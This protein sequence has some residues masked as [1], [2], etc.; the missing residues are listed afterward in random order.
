MKEA[1]K[2]LVKD[3]KEIKDKPFIYK[4]PSI[5]TSI[6]LIATILI[7]M[8]F[9]LE[10]PI[11]AIALAGIGSIS[12]AVDGKLARKFN[13]SSNFGAK[14]DA[15]CDKLFIFSLGISL[16]TLLPVLSK[17]LVS[18]MLINEAN[19]TRINMSKVFVHKKVKTTQIGRVK[20]VVLCVSLLLGFISSLLPILNIPTII[21]LLTAI[22]LQLSTM[23]SYKEQNLE[24]KK[25]EVVIKNNA[26]LET[27]DSN[28][29]EKQMLYTLKQSLE[30][31][32]NIEQEKRK[33]LH[34]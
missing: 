20:M 5:I 21:S 1:W 13:A 2:E 10:L 11:V 19:I 23:K 15:M 16:I 31:N 28:E 9:I 32:I 30:N 8:F 7:P 24:E 14:L 4:L 18:I 29:Y 26:S 25:E 34:L 33:E 3:F 6:R 17:I 12:D 27:M 22:G